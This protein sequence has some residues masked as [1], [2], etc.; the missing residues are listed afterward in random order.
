MKPLKLT[1]QAFG[2]YA[3]EQTL[4]FADLAGRSF[5]LICGPTGAGKTSVLDGMCYALYGETSGER[6]GKQMRSDH[7]ALT[8]PT[9][10]AFEFAVGG[11][12]YRVTRS[13]EQER[14]K[15]RGQG[16]KRESAKA[17]LL[18]LDGDTETPL[19]TSLREVGER[20]ERILGFR[21][22]QFRQV[23]MLP[24]GRFRELLVAGSTEREKILEHL[25]R[26]HVYRRLQETM[27]A[28]AR[29][30]DQELQRL[31]EKRDTLLR[32]A[33]AA[34]P[35]QLRQRHAT[36]EAR[37][38]I[39]QARL[40]R[41]RACRDA[42]QA[43]LAEAR[44]SA[45]RIREMHRAQEVLDALTARQTEVAARRDE[46]ERARR[47]LG[48]VDVERAANARHEEAKKAAAAEE[49]AETNLQRVTRQR[50]A[51][52]AAHERQTA[53]EE[54]RK[55]ARNDVARLEPLVAQVRQLEQ[56]RRQLTEARSQL[57]E[58]ESAGKTAASRLEQAR[59]QLQSAQERM[60]EL[61]EVAS[62]A[63]ACRL[64]ADHL[65]RQC[66]SRRRLD[67]A[68]Q[69]H[70]EAARQHERSIGDLQSA[71]QAYAQARR[72]LETLQQ[73]WIA[74]QSAVLAGQLIEGEPCP[75]CGSTHHPQ[76][77]A[78]SDAVPSEARI[79]TAQ[80][81]VENAERARDE[82]G[83]RAGADR[84]AAEACHAKVQELQT[85]L[86]ET[87][88][89]SLDE[90]DERAKRARGEL[91]RAESATQEAAALNERVATLEKQCAEATA[92]LQTAEASLR[93]QAERVRQWQGVVEARAAGIPDNLRT[94]DEV[95]RRL[96]E[97]KK[98]LDDLLGALE[99]AR[100]AAESAE[101]QLAGATESYHHARRQAE[102]ARQV[103][104]Q[105]QSEF[106]ERLASQGF[107][108]VAA[109]RSAR[110]SDRD[111]RQLHEQIEEYDHQLAAAK[112]RLAR[113][114]KTAEGLAMPDLEAAEKRYQRAADLLERLIGLKSHIKGT[115]EEIAR[116][117]EELAGTA[118]QYAAAEKQYGIVG[119]LSELANGNNADRLTFQRF[120]LGSFLDE[121]LDAA[122]Q[123]LRIMSRGRFTLQ[124]V[125]EQADGRCAGGLD[126]E[127]EDSYTG[128]ARPVQTLSGG[129]S[130]EASLA[131]ALGLADV[132][133]AHAGGVRLDSVFIDEGFG[134]LDPE[135]LDLAIR[136]LM[137]L[138]RDG[139][140][141]GIISH[142]PELRERID[143]RLEVTAGRSGST[144]RFVIA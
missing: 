62:Q 131:L 31:S 56:D 136:A 137:D 119:R 129:E 118:E 72:A 42:L 6:D 21:G 25:F 3:D 54:E 94:A 73:A 142:V 63:Q 47:A 49:D 8:T 115:L 102:A 10:V 132:V 97:A 85:A 79:K 98:R 64:A 71:E 134:S 143:A 133:Q 61:Q 144:A 113:A 127:V 17:E 70:A 51:A 50:D 92:R 55:Q 68:R 33:R 77:A 48:L 19:A 95:E 108:D 66:E 140:L 122:S 130:F 41:V 105:Q 120:V 16:M 58:A 44:A 103:A 87:A 37:G 65:A 22:D 84:A 117:L 26:T 15:R 32:H 52:V 14:P 4:D 135:A 57:A 34:S 28:R 74:G 88:E 96:D 40:A 78:A 139:R 116:A 138:H 109:Y 5:F 30:L 90:F 99:A 53:R 20:I 69:D 67:R 2:P 123:R 128:T 45:D 12:T 89:I 23:V 112:D 104:D 80:A 106:L 9:R 38:A 121:V 107:A 35:E 124:R 29:G 1:M 91:D 13:P 60:R 24:Q 82:C 86:G 39:V 100:T 7:A 93:E 11:R 43:E 27:K 81:E 101:K 36:H 76:P 18:Q 75:V 59:Q 141:V 83:L 111:M 126:L 46:L 125:R 114:R 110:K